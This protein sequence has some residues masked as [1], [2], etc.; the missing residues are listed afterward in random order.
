MGYRMKLEEI[1]ECDI[2]KTIAC[3]RAPGQIQQAMT[4]L[5][6]L[7]MSQTAFNVSLE[8]LRLLESSIGRQVNQGSAIQVAVSFW[9]MSL[10][11]YINSILR[12]ACIATSRNFEEVKKKDFA[13]RI[14]MIFDFLEVDPLPFYKGTFQRLEDFKTYRNELF[15]DRTNFGRL[16][17]HKTVFSGNPFYSNQ[18]DVMQAA[19]I[20]IEVFNKLRHLI[21]SVDLMPK[22]RVSKGQSFFFQDIDVMYKMVLVPYFRRCLE[23]HG[24]ESEVALFQDETPLDESKKIKGIN[25]N[26]LMKHEFDE[27]YR[28]V[29]NPI[30]TNHAEDLM[31]IIRS[32]QDFDDTQSFKLGNFRRTKN[33]PTNVSTQKMFSAIGAASHLFSL[34]IHLCRWGSYWSRKI[35]SISSPYFY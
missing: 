7:G 33:Q 2:G 18:V 27:K 12:I 28:I 31:S 24:I 6:Y 3:I 25:I 21:P 23:K 22:I 17:F 1:R 30:E 29:P 13:P 35:Y 9:F 19:S 4:E 11:S 10:E 14:S 26:I 15:H 34:N 20:A 32:E 16:K 8:Q 5:T